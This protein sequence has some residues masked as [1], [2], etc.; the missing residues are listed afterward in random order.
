M[1]ECTVIVM[2]LGLH[3]SSSDERHMGKESRH[4]L[5]EDMLAAITF[6]TNFSA[7]RADR[8]GVWRSALPQHFD[9]ARS[10]G[11]FPG[12]RM[13]PKGHKC[14]SLRNKTRGYQQVYNQFYDGMFNQNCKAECDGLVYNC[15]LDTTSTEV[16]TI[17]KF[18]LDNGLQQPAAERVVS[19]EILRWNT[20][21]IFDVPSWHTKN[22][23]CSHF[24]Y[25]P[26]LYETALERLGILLSTF[27]KSPL[28][29][30]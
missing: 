28:T 15:T 17:H 18:L 20:F 2:N 19:G 22:N 24:C 9:V 30:V 10:F 12:W 7:S 6:L 11:H 3:Y 1:E 16:Q 14:A 25:V 23:D 27:L 8:I 4:P 21:D 26:A 13:L 29:R 5:S